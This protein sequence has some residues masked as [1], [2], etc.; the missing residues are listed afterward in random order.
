MHRG[1]LVSVLDKRVDLSHF[2]L[3]VAGGGLLSFAN[4]E[5]VLIR[6]KC[7]GFPSPVSSQERGQGGV[8]IERELFIGQPSGPNPLYHRDD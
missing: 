1:I 4:R 5:Y 2:V 6:N 3:E 7:I 8:Q